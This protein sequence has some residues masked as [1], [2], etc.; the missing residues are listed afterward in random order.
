MKTHVLS[1]LSRRSFSVLAL[2]C[3][4]AAARGQTV[5]YPFDASDI[6]AGAMV[7]LWSADPRAAAL[8]GTVLAHEGDVIAIQQSGHAGQ[9]LHFALSHLDS[10]QMPIE[11]HRDTGRWMT[12]G[13]AAGAAIGLAAYA[14]FPARGTDRR[15]KGSLIAADVAGG[16][17]AG[18]AIGAIVS[19]APTTRWVTVQLHP[20]QPR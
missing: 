1:L 17:F 3:V 7:R 10:L 11:G 2:C 4:S 8:R 5:Y 15:S 13:G 9:T 6:R 14:L 18:L 16:A 12:I 20:R 19:L